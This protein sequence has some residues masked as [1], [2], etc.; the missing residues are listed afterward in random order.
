MSGATKEIRSNRWLL[1]AVCAIGLFAGGVASAD[2]RHHGG[3]DF[4]GHSN[5][6]H[7]RHDD[8]HRDWRDERR[9][10]PNDA[11]HDRRYS[12]RR[13]YRGEY[14]RRDWHYYQGRYWAPPRY[15]GRECSDRRHHH[16][17]HYHVAAR[18]YYDYYYPRYRYYGSRPLSADASVIITIP[19]F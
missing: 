12:D 11:H 14:M 9:W 8:R 18:D 13:S 2:D 10:S 7:E 16:S 4:R 3:R 17:V 19:L 6:G 15:R 5:R 1:P